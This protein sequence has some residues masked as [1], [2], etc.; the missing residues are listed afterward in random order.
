M[1]HVAEKEHTAGHAGIAAV[2]AL[3]GNGEQPVADIVVAEAAGIEERVADIEVPAVGIG[4]RLEDIVAAAELGGSRAAAL[5]PALCDA[6]PEW[7]WVA[8]AKAWPLG[9][10][11]R[12]VDFRSQT[13]GIE[14]GNPQLTWSLTSNCN[15]WEGL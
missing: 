1:E 4:A 5:G 7:D 8:S 13:W 12:S 9:K 15:V 2:V 10:V 14:T 11:G 6:A 3:A